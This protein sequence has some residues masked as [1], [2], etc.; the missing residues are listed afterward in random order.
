MDKKS[1]NILIFTGSVIILSAILI[2]FFSA[3]PKTKSSPRIRADKAKVVTDRKEYKAGS[4]LK[5]KIE[6]DLDRDICFSSCYPYYFERKDGSW[7]RYEYSNCDKEDLAKPCAQPKSVK[8]FELTIPAS[9]V[10]KGIHRLA[11][12][13]CIGCNVKSKFRK[14]KWLYSNSFLIK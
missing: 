11:I 2:I 8:A 1:K 10:K 4:D 7:D 3:F 14:D 12:P 9:L 13:A 5:V 6:N